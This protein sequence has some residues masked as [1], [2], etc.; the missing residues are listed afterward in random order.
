MAGAALFAHFAKGAVLEF[1]PHGV[2]PIELTSLLLTYVQIR[3]TLSRVTSNKPR[4]LLPS[5]H[6]WQR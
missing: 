1:S 3:G 5:F 4:I 6:A 2:H